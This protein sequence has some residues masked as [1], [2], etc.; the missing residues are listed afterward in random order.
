MEGYRGHTHPQGFGFSLHSVAVFSLLPYSIVLYIFQLA[1][2][3]GRLSNKDGDLAAMLCVGGDLFCGVSM[4][5]SSSE[6]FMIVFSNFVV[7]FLR[8][9]W[10]ANASGAGPPTFFEQRASIYFVFSIG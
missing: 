7:C 10:L 8:S 3:E 5:F 9:V 4:H 1:E 2:A 6:I